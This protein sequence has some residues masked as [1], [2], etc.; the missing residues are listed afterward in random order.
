M[1]GKRKTEFVEFC[2]TQQALKF[3]SFTLK[4]GRQSPFFF[5]AGSFNSGTSVGELGEFYADALVSSGLEFDHLFGPAYKGIPL[6]T[7]TAIGLRGHKKDIPFTFN[8]KVEKDH[9]EGGV[10]VGADL[11]NKKV[12][13]VDDVITAGTAIR[14]SLTL[15]E[16]IPGCTVVGVLV[17]LDRQEKVSLEENLS[18]IQKVE[19]EFKFPVISIIQLGD[20]QLYLKDKGDP[21]LDAVVQYRE[22]YGVN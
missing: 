8:R 1:D 11:A 6:V 20:L 18:A 16:K 2:L 21:L 5:N 4:S 3:G 7:A 15:L 13:I 19:Q 12:I 17:A 10:F 9:G 22:Q 14:E